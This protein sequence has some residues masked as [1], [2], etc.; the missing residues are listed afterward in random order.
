MTREHV[1]EVVTRHLVDT[2]EELEGV[3]ID[4][5]KS[6]K[7]LGANSLDIVEVVSCSMRELKVKVPRAELN[8]L[9]NINQLVEL[10]YKSVQEKESV[11][12]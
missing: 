11:S 10:L 5:A 4:P 1:L 3:E 9:E 6:M 12:S 7:D 8:K 2:I